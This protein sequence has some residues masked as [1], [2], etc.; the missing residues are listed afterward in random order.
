MRI[1]L[2][3]TERHKLGK[4]WVVLILLLL[5]HTYKKQP[6]KQLFWQ[7][8]YPRLAM[9]MKLK[10]QLHSSRLEYRKV[11]M[12]NMIVQQQVADWLEGFWLKCPDF[13]YLHI[14]SGVR[15]SII[16]IMV[17]IGMYNG[18]LIYTNSI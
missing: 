13:A 18:I 10:P 6:L 14:M 15:Q 16:S 12:G 7:L 3:Q 4:P 1:Q 17:R 11:R 8:L 9:Q 5:C 2:G